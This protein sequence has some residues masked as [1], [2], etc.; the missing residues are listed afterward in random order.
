MRKAQPEADINLLPIM[1]LFV[2]LIPFLLMGIS[3]LQVGS[4]DG[5]TPVMAGG[6]GAQKQP[7]VV[8][9]QIADTALQIQVEPG[10]EAEGATSQTWTVAKDDTF[11]VEGALVPLMQAEVKARYPDANSL[12]LIPQPTLPY[13]QV[14]EVMS[15]L[16][17]LFPQM[18]VTTAAR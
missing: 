11:S 5:S 3:F 7:T 8:T 6:T 13:A 12:V 1:N 17:P 2:V 18:T 15:G 9:V 4:L 14:I 10:E 16:R